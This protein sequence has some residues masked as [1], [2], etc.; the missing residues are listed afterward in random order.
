[1][2]AAGDRCRTAHVEDLTPPGMLGSQRAA[3]R[4]GGRPGRSCTGARHEL[5]GAQDAARAL[6]EA[7][8][9]AGQAHFRALA[10]LATA[11]A[12]AAAGDAEPAV[13]EIEAGLA[14]LNDGD[15]P[16]IVADLGLEFAGLLQSADRVTALSEAR[17]ALAAFT[18]GAARMHDAQALLH[19]LGDSLPP[20]KPPP[21]HV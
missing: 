11:R 2:N 4:R 18:A 16:L 8:V 19:A 21:S 10:A 5:A 17:M 12:L 6:Q 13:A 14:A 1:M 9:I 3:S 20:S 15:W 7:A